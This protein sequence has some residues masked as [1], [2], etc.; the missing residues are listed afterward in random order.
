[1][2]SGG[3][4]KGKNVDLLCFGYGK[5]YRPIALVL[6][7]RQN[8]L[9]DRNSRV[10]RE[11]RAQTRQILPVCRRRRH[12]C[13]PCVLW[14]N[15]ATASY[16]SRRSPPGVRSIAR[17]ASKFAARVQ[18]GTVARVRGRITGFRGLVQMSSLMWSSRWTP[19]PRFWLDC[20]RLTRKCY[21][22]AR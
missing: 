8:P 10:R 20:V 13:I 17:T 11:S 12:R 1:M 14:L 9:T 4:P 15:H 6:N 7:Q 22:A 16:F 19:M 5:T 3:C 21:G 18:V 2:E